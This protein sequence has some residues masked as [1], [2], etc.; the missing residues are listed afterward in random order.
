MNRTPMNSKFYPS[1][2][3][4]YS[5]DFIKKNEQTGKI[6]QDI[7]GKMNQQEKN[8]ENDLKFLQNFNKS[9][10]MHSNIIGNGLGYT[11]SLMKSTVDG[12]AIEKVKL[13]IFNFR[14]QKQLH[15]WKK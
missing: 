14:A 13:K 12:T 3:Q 10:T 9:D 2:P 15:F 8:N 11:D 4:E 5:M 7:S 1:K 6:F